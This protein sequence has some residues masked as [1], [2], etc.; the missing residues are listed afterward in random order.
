MRGMSTSSLT[1]FLVARDAASLLQLCVRADRPALHAQSELAPASAPRRRP[2]SLQRLADLVLQLPVLDHAVQRPL[3][4]A[5]HPGR[6]LAVAVG[7]LQRLLDVVALD[8][9]QRPADQVAGAGAPAVRRCST[10]GA[11]ALLHV[12]QARAR[13]RW[14]CTT[15][16]SIRLRSSRT[17]PGQS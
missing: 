6:L 8:L 4:D 16:L 1:R 12:V 3:A 7:Q 10:R 11:V 15:M 5:E 2:T 17:L 13:R 14:S 9:A